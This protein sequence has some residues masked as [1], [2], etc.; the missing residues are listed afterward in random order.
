M[1]AFEPGGGTTTVPRTARAD[2]PVPV[3]TGRS[4]PPAPAARVDEDRFE[5]PPAWR[6]TIIPRRGGAAGP[7]VHAGPASVAAADEFLAPLRPGIDTLLADP[8]TDPRIAA[9]ARAHLT[10]EPTAAGAAA[11]AAAASHAYGWGNIDRMRALADG[12]VAAHGVVFAASAV[13]ELSGL[14]VDHGPYPPRGGRVRIGRHTDLSA[15]GWSHHAHWLAVA[16]R[17][18]AHLAAAAGADHAAAVDAL[19]ALRAGSA[20]QR[21]AICFLLPTQTAWVDQ[22][23]AALPA[24]SD[25]AV[26]GLLWCAVGSLPQLDLIAEHVRTWWVI[27]HQSLVTTAVDGIGPAIAP[28]LADWFDRDYADADARQRLLDALAVLPTDEALRLQLDRLDQP[29]VAASVQATA[30]RFPVR[31]V[32]LLAEAAG[33]PTAGARTAAEL[34]RA[35][36]LAHPAA[37]AAALP[38]L[39]ADARRRVAAIQD[40]GTDP[41][42]E[43]P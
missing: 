41:R 10:G 37:T 4:Q 12:W 23:C 32:R 6:R 9:A 14:V 38:A 36:V 30:R 3:Q 43:M 21:V 29:R 28:R 39:S 26:G 7:P 24:T 22:E 20:R 15:T 17:T 35:H 16:A 2:A 11:V 33:G 13:V 40:A 42:K 8:H 1:R 27:Q 5:L 18:R 34:L 31:A 19:A 25:Y